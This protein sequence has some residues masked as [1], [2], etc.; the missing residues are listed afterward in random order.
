VISLHNFTSQGRLV[1]GSTNASP[2]QITPEFCSLGN[3]KHER[4]R[5]LSG[6]K[7]H[8]VSLFLRLDTYSIEETAT[9][10]FFRTCLLF[11]NGVP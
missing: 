3:I 10:A 5:F 8:L 6:M 1:E 11:Q 2:Y 9:Q 7:P 4:E